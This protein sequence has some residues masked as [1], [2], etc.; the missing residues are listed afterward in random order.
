LIYILAERDIEANNSI[1]NN[2]CDGNAA[3]GAKHA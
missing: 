1:D 3:D 2:A